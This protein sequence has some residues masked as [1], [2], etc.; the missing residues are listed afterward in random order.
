MTTRLTAKRAVALPDTG[1]TVAPRESAADGDRPDRTP[2]GPQLGPSTCPAPSGILPLGV[3]EAQRRRVPA[4]RTGEETWHS[5]TSSAWTAAAASSSSCRASSETSRSAVPRVV[6][7]PYGRSSRASS[8]GHPRRRPRPALL[9]RDRLS[10]EAE[11]WRRGRA[12]SIPVRGP[13]GARAASRPGTQA[14][15]CFAPAL[16]CHDSRTPTHCRRCSPPSLPDR[17]S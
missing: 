8:A 9:V 3:C 17:S 7:P 4:R 10:P 15:R 2:W 6:P 5:T 13:T 11:S 12:A 1:L 14:P 16:L